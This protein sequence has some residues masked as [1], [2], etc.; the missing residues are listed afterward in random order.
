MEREKNLKLNLHRYTHWFEFMNQEVEFWLQDNECHTHS[1][2]ARVLL[3]PL[4][5]GEQ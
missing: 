2:C 1:H 3:Y 4:V 5:I